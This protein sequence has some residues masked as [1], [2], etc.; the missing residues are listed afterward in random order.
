MVD[1]DKPRFVKI[2]RLTMSVTGGTVPEPDMLR[3]WWYK[4]HKFDVD[5]IAAA[6]DRY[7]SESEY[8]P[9]PASI[10]KMIGEMF[11]NQEKPFVALP[12][13]EQN[14]EKQR[15]ELKKIKQLIEKWQVK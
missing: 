12:R 6:F 8:P 1:D 4:L 15:E 9:K 14:L 7:T 11:P 13:P 3:F 2:L 5:Q 10:L